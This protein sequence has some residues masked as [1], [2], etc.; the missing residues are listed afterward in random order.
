MVLTEGQVPAYLISK[1][2]F[3]Q[4]EAIDVAPLG[5]GLVN[6]LFLARS[7]K[8][9]VV[10]KQAEPVMKFNR[11]F[12]MPQD[13]VVTEYDALKLWRALGLPYAPKPLLLDKKRFLLVMEAVGEGAEMLTFQLMRGKVDVPLLRRLGTTYGRLHGKTRGKSRLKTAFP[14]TGGFRMLKIGLYYKDMAESAKSPKMRELAKRCMEKLEKNRLCFIQ[15]D[16]LPKNILVKGNDFFIIDHEVS[17]YGDPAQDLAVFFS[18]MVSSAVINWPLRK[19]Y[20]RGIREFMKSYKKEAGWGSLFRKIEANS[21]AYLPANLFG[22][23]CGKVKIDLLDK[24]T[25]KALVRVMERIVAEEPKKIASVF[26]MVDEEGKALA[27]NKPWK[28]EAIHGRLF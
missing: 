1:G 5:G 6:H 12:R 10:L 24:K 23:A 21:I 13:R 2:L 19:R 11:K 8:R 27:R 20:Y 22:R 25:E 9:A 4:G 16:L 14:M 7:S 17:Y 26:R 15:G 18:A 28:K 3:K